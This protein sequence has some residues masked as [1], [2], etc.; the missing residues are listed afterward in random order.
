MAF[1]T[2]IYSFSAPKIA[3]RDD[4]RAA[5]MAVVRCP[6]FA[7]FFAYDDT[8]KTHRQLL[9]YDLTTFIYS[10]KPFNFGVKLPKVSLTLFRGFKFENE[11]LVNFNRNVDFLPVF[12]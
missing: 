3:R 1:K 8:I 5:F 10:I 7:P 11:I 2:S 12:G 6:S 4:L 9:V